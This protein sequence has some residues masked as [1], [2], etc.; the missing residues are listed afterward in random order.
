LNTPEDFDVEQ[1]LLSAC[2][3][4]SSAI[5]DCVDKGVEVETFWTPTNQKLWLAMQ[6][7]IVAA[8][9]G[10]DSI[11]PMQL[12][13]YATPRAPEISL[14]DLTKLFT[15]MGT[16]HNVAWHAQTLLELQQRRR[17]AEMGRSLSNRAVD[18]SDD[19][20]DTIFDLEEQLLRNTRSDESG[21]IAL[22]K[23][24]DQTELWA[25]QN[26]GLGLLGLSTG[27]DKLDQITNGLQPGQVMILAA[28]PSKGKS[29]LA[30]QIASHIAYAGPV[31]YFSLEMDARSLVLRA[32]CQ[33]TAIPI[34]D[35]ARNNIPPQAQESYDAAV[36]NLRTQQLHVDERGSVTM[37]ALKSR[38]KRLH[39]KEPLRLIVVDYLQLMTAKQATTRE[40]EVSQ[41]SRSI[42]ALAMD[43]G[44]P[45]L[46]VAQL[47]RSI[48]MR[49]GEQSRPTLSDLR[50]SG[51]IEQDA[52]IVG[53]VWWGWEHCADLPPN[54]C[55]LI[56]RKNRN[57]PL[58][59]M[60][61]DW[62]PEQVKFVER[63]AS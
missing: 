46:A 44:V 18:M 40:Q 38:S 17:L 6:D 14:V 10:T 57:G 21:L 32:L 20:D 29:A 2:M 61:I 26:S 25:R 58:G 55:E 35:L 62:K 47:N 49:T 5:S 1:A 48:E 12:L 33:E 37:H 23:A 19:P 59:T 15:L 27:F 30:W 41:I 11:D 36:A 24:I 34:S 4:R 9:A 50:D 13:R 22:N 7:A 16:S 54:D 53:M 28:R 52:D 8:P 3:Q 63:K 42:K 56:V 45:I 43:L 60:I 51:Q 39:R 31:A